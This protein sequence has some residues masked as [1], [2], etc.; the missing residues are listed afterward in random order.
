MGVAVFL[1][2]WALRFLHEADA[3]ADVGGVFNLIHQPLMVPHRKCDF[4]CIAGLA[5]QNALQLTGF[6]NLET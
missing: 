4:I 6:F 2:S 3:F 5:H 1:A